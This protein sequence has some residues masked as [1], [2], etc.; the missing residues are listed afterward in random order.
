MRR[1]PMLFEAHNLPHVPVRWLL[2]SCG[3]ESTLGKFLDS[4]FPEGSR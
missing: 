4:R 3:K 2:M 1:K